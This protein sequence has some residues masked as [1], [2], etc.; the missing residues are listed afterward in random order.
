MR[1]TR[2]VRQG[3]N[4]EAKKGIK[5][6]F[7][8]ILK[9]FAI[10]FLAFFAFRMIQFALYLSQESKKE[11]ELAIKAK[12][13]TDRKLA[14]FKAMTPQL[15][16][17][18]AKRLGNSPLAYK[19]LAAVPDDF[20]GKK[21]LVA[22]L[23]QEK[24]KVIAAQKRAEKLEHQKILEDERKQ[25]AKW[26]KEGVSIGMTAERA[27]LSSWGIPNKVNRTTSSRGVREQWVYD[28]GYL[29]FEDGV[30]VSIQN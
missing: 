17:D 4:M 30:L 23:K 27:K 15:H 11:Q 25:R 13:E 2:V 12:S 1:L 8:K 21:A 9:W 19:H 6:A 28:G 3:V 18:A 5:S 24:D 10:I 7:N 16:L 26:R 29:Y 22:V 14:E 20:A